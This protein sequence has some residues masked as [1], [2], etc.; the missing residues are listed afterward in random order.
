ML[1][2]IY[3]NDIIN[4]SNILLSGLIADDTTVNVQ[5]DSIDGEI[6]IV[7]SAVVK[8]AKW[9]YFNKLTLNVNKP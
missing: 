9:F 2:L 1:F 5:H 4:F 7:I 8:V 3:I 6:D